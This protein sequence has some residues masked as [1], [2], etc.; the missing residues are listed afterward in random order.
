MPFDRN[1]TSVRTMPACD[2][3]RNIVRRQ[4][5]SFQRFMSVPFDWRSKLDLWVGVLVCPFR[6]IINSRIRSSRSHESLLTNSVTMH[7]IDM[8][9]QELDIK[10][11]HSSI[12]G[13]DHCLQVSTSHGSKY[14]SCRTAEEREKWV[15]RY[16]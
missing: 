9:S 1:K 5:P 10:P 4:I 8:A 16:V 6:S 12:L 3:N 14:I 13:Q 2:R 15:G 11:L 7:S